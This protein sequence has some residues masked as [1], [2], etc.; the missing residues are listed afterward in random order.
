[1]DATYS[2]AE[3]RL[4]WLE[5]AVDDLNKRA[6]RLRVEPL[7]LE[8]LGFE[9]RTVRRNLDERIVRLYSVRLSGSSPRINGWTLQ[10]TLDHTAEGGTLLRAV[11]GVGLPVRFRDARPEDCDHCRTRRQR[12]DTFVLRHDETGRYAQVGR[13]CLRDFLGHVDP[14]GIAALCELLGLA[15]EAAQTAADDRE[16]EEGGARGV[17]RIPTDHLLALT[18]ATVRAFGWVSRGTARTTDQSA[19]AD[20]ALQLDSAR[21]DRANWMR[22]VEVTDADIAAAAATIEL[23]R[24]WADR[25]DL[26][27][28]EYNLL[29]VL[30]GAGV[31]ERQAGIACSAVTVYRRQ[32]EREQVAR[33]ETTSEYVGTV[34]QRLTAEVT[35]LGMQEI[36][37]RSFSYY[38]SGVSYLY[39]FADAQGNLLQWFASSNQ[40]LT[41]G[42]TYRLVGTVKKHD[43]YKGTRRTTLTRC[44]A[45]VGSPA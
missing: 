41:D 34:G 45:A 27:D 18:F 4:P 15:H 28:Y 44:R 16:Y 38:D 19:T 26:S 20:L 14:H 23:V 17:Y 12:N 36:G 2:I 8:V 25:T 24:G 35:L 13:Q 32:Q 42:Q 9:D 30:K 39:R 37:G 7:T 11:P 21:G 22:A 6:K 1:M 29:T 40:E 31:T 10:A 33:V 43:E 5:K 3:H